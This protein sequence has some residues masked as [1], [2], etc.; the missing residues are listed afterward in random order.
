MR[1]AWAF[2]L[3]LLLVY[4]SPA[5]AADVSQMKLERSEDTVFLS[6]SVKFDLPPV[7]EDALLKGIPLFFVAEA[8]IYRDR[9]YWYDKRVTTATRTLRLA[10]QPLTRRWR[11]NVMS[12]AISV[13]GLRASLS[14]S[15]DSLPEAL[16]SIQRISRWRI[17]D[18]A[19]I[20][21][22]ARHNVQFRF[23]LDLSQLPR[24][25]QIGVAGQKDWAVSI[26]ETRQLV[27]E[28][29]REASK[30]PGKDPVPEVSK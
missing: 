25:F 23:R 30:D 6:A 17:A 24:P 14:Q 29:I 11:L 28:P 13:T 27:A 5:L 3:C 18:A 22:D 2:C 1:R 4:A 8:D 10:Y 26:E 7:V 21:S 9:W 12:G 20:E 16:A 19:E 15:Y